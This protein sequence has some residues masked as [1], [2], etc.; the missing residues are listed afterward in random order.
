MSGFPT[1]GWALAAAVAA[2]PVHAAGSRNVQ[3]SLVS[4]TASIEPGQPLQLGLRLLMADGWHTYWKNPA[5]SGLP[6]KLKWTLPDG[7]T[8]DAIE[9]P[10]PERI[11]APPLMS[12]GYE[13]EV[14]LPVTVHPPATLPAGQTLRLAARADWLECKEICLPGKAD[15]EIA[16]PVA[17]GKGA[18]SDA[19]ALFA[20]TRRDL[21]TDG[22]A[23]RLKAL[24]TEK[25]LAL[26]FV[27][28]VMPHEAYFFSDQPQVVEY[29]EPQKLMRT[30]DSFT[31]HLTPAANG[32]RP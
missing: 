32:A 10:R 22:A 13:D 6:T 20:K 8:A 14:L 2:A 12:Y 9:W 30:G 29:A 19:A 7:F 3:A 18:P 24:A 5:D 25:R 31:L 23:W 11:S 26:S 17:A 4:E 27:P 21:P 16:L 28:S 15:V 1:I